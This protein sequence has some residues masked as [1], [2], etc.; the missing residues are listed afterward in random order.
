MDWC[1]FK[2]IPISSRT[3]AIFDDEEHKGHSYY[4][5][6]GS[7]KN[8]DYWDCYCV[9]GRGSKPPTKFTDLLKRVYNPTDVLKWYHEFQFDM[10]ICYCWCCQGASPVLIYAWNTLSC[11]EC[12]DCEECKNYEKIYD[13]WTPDSGCHGFYV[14]NDGELVYF[15][16][17]MRYRAYNFMTECHEIHTDIFLLV[18][19]LIFCLNNRRSFPRD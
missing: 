1:E 17:K 6:W 14:K 5:G 18:S 9:G 2:R 15:G 4:T 8:G 10:I 12:S 19:F 7:G 13:N 3:D 16:E 11:E